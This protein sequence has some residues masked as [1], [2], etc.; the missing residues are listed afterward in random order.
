MQGK[1]YT[2]PFCTVFK[3]SR[4]SKLFQNKEN[5]THVQ[6]LIRIRFIFEKISL[7]SKDLFY[8]VI[9]TK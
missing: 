5:N 2:E 1:V 8:I 7:L 3:T 6:V 9:L 4:Y